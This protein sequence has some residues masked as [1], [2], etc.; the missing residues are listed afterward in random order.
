MGA[1]ERSELALQTQLRLVED[2]QAARS[3]FDAIAR[4]AGSTW[5]AIDDAGCIE[6][7]SPSW[8]KLS[9]KPAAELLAKAW[10]A[11]FE[12]APLEAGHLL[13][14]DARDRDRPVRARRVEIGAV[15][16]LLELQPLAERDGR[17][18]QA[19][20]R[21]L[22]LISE[23]GDECWN[24]L[25]ER[26]PQALI[27][28]DAEGRL[29]DF[30]GAAAALAGPEPW[31]I[32]AP[33]QPFLEACGLRE[34]AIE[35]VL[36]RPE[37]IE[38]EW[39]AVRPLGRRLR[40]SARCR[41][42]V[43]GERLV[44]IHVLDAEAE[45]GTLRESFLTALSH[46]MKTPLTSIRGFGELLLDGAPAHAEDTELL[47][48]LV[49]E[50]Y[51]VESLIDELLRLA[52]VSANLNRARHEPCDFVPL[53]W[54]A[55][56]RATR[57]AQERHVELAV[58]RAPERAHVVL[59]ER[60]MFLALDQLLGHALERSPAGA[61]VHVELINEPRRLTLRVFDQGRPQE[62]PITDHALRDLLRGAQVSSEPADAGRRLAMVEAIARGHGGRVQLLEARDG[63]SGVELSLPLRG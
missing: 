41:S 56:F 24:W 63:F 40:V 42:G 1:P 17:T 29:T 30:N 23:A 53:L 4:R 62:V 48:R 38:R 36:D 60:L 59:D 58:V 11:A 50:S 2:L 55:L 35:H 39:P 27:A 20:G 3:R 54:Q 51:R 43:D 45:P 22:S 61:E 8:L 19:E 33:A 26:L 25:Q 31:E 28:V 57:G 21:A 52:E 16:W 15:G 46:E 7:L 10:S 37:L 13:P 44:L 14:V 5:L 18:S 34:E 12:E 49:H 32:G 6:Y 9:R 47:R